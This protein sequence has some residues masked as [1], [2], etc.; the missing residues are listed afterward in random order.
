MLKSISMKFNLNLVG[1]GVLEI[2][3]CYSSKFQKVLNTLLKSYV[4]LSELDY[5]IYHSIIMKP[6]KMRW[7]FSSRQQFK[8]LVV[9]LT[10]ANVSL[11]CIDTFTDLDTWFQILSLVNCPLHSDSEKCGAELWNARGFSFH[12][13]PRFCHM[14]KISQPIVT[15]M[16]PYLKQNKNQT[17]HRASGTKT[18]LCLQDTISLS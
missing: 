6:M 15:R 13:L 4:L 9:T 8:E 17:W 2:S 7:L 3:R 16:S 10:K 5:K 1:F 14:L 12:H 18:D 11:L